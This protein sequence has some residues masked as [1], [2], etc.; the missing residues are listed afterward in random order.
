VAGA[1]QL[2]VLVREALAAGRPAL[3]PSVRRELARLFLLDGRRDRAVGG[4]TA[5]HAGKGAP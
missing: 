3:P 4:R 5:P 1:E 2:E